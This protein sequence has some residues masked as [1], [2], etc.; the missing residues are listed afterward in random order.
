MDTLF[1][2]AATSPVVDREDLLPGGERTRDHPPAYAPCPH[3]GLAVLTGMTDEGTTV[4]L[5]P[6]QRCYVVL[7]LDNAP[8][9]QLRVSAAYPVH[10]CTR[11]R[12]D[13]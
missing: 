7:W 8:Q 9:P 3:C 11:H 6:H 13:A 12:R 10:L 5:D 2:L 1:D 4:A